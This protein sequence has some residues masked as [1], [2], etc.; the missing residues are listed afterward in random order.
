M[1]V[2]GKL[3]MD[4]DGP[5]V[6]EL[7]QLIITAPLMT[8]QRLQIW[9]QKFLIDNK[10]SYT[11]CQSVAVDSK[12]WLPPNTSLKGFHEENQATARYKNN[13]KKLKHKQH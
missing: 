5:T 13:E 12:Q 1:K 8:R 11:K 9:H 2:D 4:R 3:I 10:V 6:T 7:C